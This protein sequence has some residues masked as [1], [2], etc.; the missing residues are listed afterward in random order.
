ML[1]SRPI[2][3]NRVIQMKTK[4]G[5]K[6]LPIAALLLCLTVSS[7]GQQGMG[8]GNNNPQEMLDVSGAIK[9]GTTTTTNAGTIRWTGTEF[10]GWDGSQWITFGGGASLQLTEA[11]VDAFVA[12]N[13]YLTSE[14]DG[15][16]CLLYTSPSPRDISGS[17]MPSS[18]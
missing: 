15:D 14:A 3:K 18:A 12:N 11:D 1:H 4:M 7:Y 10:Q 17:R 6:F 13:G 8:I 9:L 5:Y 2:L 16:A